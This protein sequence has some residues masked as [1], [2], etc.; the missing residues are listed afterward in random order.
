MALNISYFAK[1]LNVIHTHNFIHQSMADRK[2]RLDIHVSV[3]KEKNIYKQKI[4][5]CKIILTTVN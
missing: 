2:Y 4:N 3:R 1:S 5:R